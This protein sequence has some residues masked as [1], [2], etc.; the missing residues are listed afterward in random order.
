[1]H[2][3]NDPDNDQTFSSESAILS[4]RWGNF[5]DE[6]S[7][8]RR[9]IVDVY[10]NN[11]KTKTFDVGHKQEIDDLSLSFSQGDHVYSCVTAING[12]G[13]LVEVKSNGFI[14]DLSPPVLKYIHD[15]KDGRLYQSDSQ[16]LSYSW[17][18]VDQESGMKLY[19]LTVFEI[20][21]GMQTKF[22]PK[23]EEFI[24]TTAENITLSGL[25]LINGR[26]YFVQIIAVNNADMP[27]SH[28]SEGV[29]IDT[30][31]PVVSQVSLT[32]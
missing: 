22:Y 21:Q 15:T 26:K 6:E 4:A 20:Y 14:I 11:V 31:V 18:F 8:I 27:V 5:L 32:C 7:K 1:V 23:D 12:A 3:G 29:I 30:S 19:R 13:L 25:S 10:V 24:S 16:T 28:K 17:K 2:D 9:Y